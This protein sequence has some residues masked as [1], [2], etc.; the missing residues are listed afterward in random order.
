MNAVMTDILIEI[1]AH[2]I[3]CPWHRGFHLH[4]RHK[5]VSGLLLRERAP[6]WSSSGPLER[7]AGCKYCGA[8]AREGSS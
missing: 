2:I 7:R 6:S 4:L 1:L 5:Y 8:Q 3:S